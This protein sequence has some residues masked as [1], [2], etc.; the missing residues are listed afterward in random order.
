MCKTDAKGYTVLSQNQNGATDV[1]GTETGEWRD[2][3]ESIELAKQ[4]H[5]Q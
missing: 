1:C 3:I 2:V 4:N 5:K